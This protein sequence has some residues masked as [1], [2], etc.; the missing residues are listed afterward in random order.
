MHFAHVRHIFFIAVF[1]AGGVM[2]EFCYVINYKKQNIKFTFTKIKSIVLLLLC[3]LML[4]ISFSHPHSIIFMV[5]KNVYSILILQTKIENN[6]PIY[7]YCI[8]L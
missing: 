7:Y 3:F 1:A 2:L 6:F 8:A 5:D 4:D